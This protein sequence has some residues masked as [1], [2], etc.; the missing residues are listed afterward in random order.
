MRRGEGL[1]LLLF[2]GV[3]AVVG[4]YLLDRRR[5]DDEGGKERQA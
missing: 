4:I 1:A 3:V 5:M 2:G